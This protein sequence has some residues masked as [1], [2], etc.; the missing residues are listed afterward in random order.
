MIDVALGTVYIFNY[1][2]GQPYQPLTAFLDLNGEANL[3]AW[4][5]SI[6]WF[7]VAALLG[8][9]ARRNFSLSQGKSW[10]L[11]ALSLVFLAFSLD[12][13]AQIHEKLGLMSDIFLPNASRKNTLFPRTGIWMFV[14]G[15]PFLALFVALILSIRSYFQRAP[16]AFIK[17]LFGLAIMMVGAIGI[18]TFDNFVAPTSVYGVLRVFLEEVC[19][20]LGGTVVLWGSYEL[21]YRHG[22]AFPCWQ[23]GR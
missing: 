3:P 17:M 12:E 13:I 6:Q 5:S 4:Y 7:C 21:L 23:N 18:E 15:I 8:I 14:I 19:E 1:L 2:A 9:F 20:M 11:A 10:L 22:V 16:S